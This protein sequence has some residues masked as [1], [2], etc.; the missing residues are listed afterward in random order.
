MIVPAAEVVAALM[1]LA[2][3]RTLQVKAFTSIQLAP[4]L[5][6]IAAQGRGLLDDL[7]PRQYTARQHLAAALPPLRRAITWPHRQATPQQLDL[8]RLL[9]AAGSAVIVLRAGIGDTLQQGAPVADLHGGEVTDTAVLG[10]LVTGQERTF[11]QNP[12]F[13]FRLLADI[14][15]RAL[16]P[17]VT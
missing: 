10:G 6:A 14:G 11:H 3:I 13:A 2:M 16:S 17:A 12:L 5:S 7:Y 9:R 1:A 4:T 15:M 8:R